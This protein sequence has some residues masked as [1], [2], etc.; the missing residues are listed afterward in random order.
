MQAREHPHPRLCLRAA[1][2]NSSIDP[3]LGSCEANPKMQSKCNLTGVSHFTFRLGI[4]P[5]PQ[6]PGADPWS[7]HHSLWS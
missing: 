1:L 6:V 2:A 3:T 7:H 5:F 4:P